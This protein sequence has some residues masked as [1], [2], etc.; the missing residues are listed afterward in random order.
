MYEFEGKI[1]YS[2]VDDCGLLRPE[3]LIDY[4]Q[5][6]ST[7]QCEDGGVGIG[8]MKDRSC[9]WIVNYWQIEVNRYPALGERV[10]TATIPYEWK[11]GFIGMRNFRMAAPD[12]EIL[13]IANSVWSLMDLQRMT[14]VRVPEDMKKVFTLQEKLE[15]DYKPRKVP[16][17]DAS[18]EERSV[19]TVGREH[20][21]SNHH[22]NNG[23]Y[24][25]FLMGAFPEESLVKGMRIEYR[26]QALLGDR[27]HVFVYPGTDPDGQGG[28]IFPAALLDDEGKPYVTAEFRVR[29]RTDKEKDAWQ[30][31]DRIIPQ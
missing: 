7:F 1:R 2:E 23:Q 5:D 11:G 28:S 26:K 13:A 21:D 30:R 22:V 20:L 6:C 31:R 15:M 4:F 19:L 25:R 8:Y 3:A 24:V 27:M 9:A 12:G 18:P 14:P 16:L 17:P 29:E 10:V